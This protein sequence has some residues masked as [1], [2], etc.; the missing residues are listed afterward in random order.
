[1]FKKY[2]ITTLCALPLLLVA[3][4]AT[5]QN[6]AIS[7]PACA[8]AGSTSNYSPVRTAGGNFVDVA[9]TWC[10]SGGTIVQ[11]YGQNVT[12]NNTCKSGT[13]IVQIVVQ[14]NNVTTG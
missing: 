11:A 7:G 12:G 6:A 3:G 14:W 2:A 9:M 5:A 10:V 13:N 4:T 1:M 8:V